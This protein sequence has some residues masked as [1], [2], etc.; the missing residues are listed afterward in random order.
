[1]TEPTQTTGNTSARLPLLLTKTYVPRA[2]PDL[3]ERPWLV[4]RLNEGLR[5]NL[6]L[7]S[8][9]AGY[10]KTTLLSKWIEVVQKPSAWLSLDERDNDPA[11]FWSYFVGA[12]Q[13]LFPG[14]GTTTLAMLQSTP[15]A[16]LENALSD[17]INEIALLTE[18]FLFVLDDFHAV[19]DDQII[20]GLAFLLE[21]FPPR[22]H[23]VVSSRTDPPFPLPLLRG[24]RQL[25]EIRLEDLR[26]YEA[27]VTLFINEIMGLDLSRT[28]IAALERLSEGWVAGLQ[29][30]AL[31][32]QGSEDV[33][34]IINSFGGSDRFVFDYL[35]QEVLARQDEQVRKFLISTSILERLSEDLCRSIL[36]EDPSEVG[37]TVVRGEPQ[38]TDEP[39][40]STDISRI[41]HFLEEANLFLVPLDHERRWY[42]YHHLFSGFLR[43]QLEREA[44]SG[45]I[46]GMHRRASR[47]YARQG[48]PS[49]AIFHALAA[50]DFTAVAGLIRASAIDL[51]KQ[52]E[53]ITLLGW[54]SELP[55]VVVAGDGHLSAIY[56]WALA[57]TSRFDEVEPQLKNIERLLGVEADG[58]QDS[59]LL[60]PETRGALGEVSLLRAVLAFNRYEIPRVLELTQQTREYLKEDVRSGLH[61]SRQ[62]LLG[63]AL[64]NLALAQEFS[65]DV[66]AATGAFQDSLPLI[67]DNLHLLPMVYSHLAQLLVVQG[68][69]HQ[70]WKTYDQAF[71][72]MEAFDRPSPFIGMLNS[73]LGNLLYEWND[74]D[75]ALFHLERGIQ[76]GKQWSHWEIL[77]AG[78]FGLTRV[79]IAR[80]D[81]QGAR[82][83]LDELTGLVSRLQVIWLLPA[84]DAYQAMLALHRGEVQAALG[85]AETF[86]AAGSALIPWIRETA[87]LILV[88]VFLAAGEWKKALLLSRQ[89]LDEAETG[90]RWGR[91]VEL[92]V[93][94]SVAL[95]ASGE[96]PPA[97]DAL[98]HALSLA[99]PE[100]YRRVFLDG[101]EP[102]RQLLESAVQS[103]P[104][105]DLAAYAQ[106]LLED[107]KKESLHPGEE[108]QPPF[109]GRRPAFRAGLPVEPLSERELQVLRL[110]A[111][112]SSNPEIAAQ[113]YISLNTVKS[114]LKN[115]YGKLGVTRRG[116]ATARARDLHLL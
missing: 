101:G 59:L 68:R 73:G 4:E 96:V 24:R 105:E 6:T 77:L 32:L 2:H 70:A 37:E 21:N 99:R 95:A 13:T 69:L 79:Q 49:E 56:A 113:L 55:E 19:K 93:L 63:A 39:L 31:S 107:F 64:F 15:P 111:A 94:Q 109:S 88:Q 14:M 65:G 3:V 1:M 52:S 36:A 27:E 43:A 11:R 40:P 82:A 108:P 42:R 83:S 100:G 72:A 84:V 20:A 30:A 33:S 57:A 25:L 23:L 51:F 26:F 48:Y 80:R 50:E 5:R 35:A 115:I 17:L 76:L 92:M 22:M 54:F 66:K 112:G 10:G 75:Q 106:S 87:N 104:G 90:Q 9:P 45:E 89:C 103:S 16:P 60:P 71:Q 78:F 67:Q 61:N 85:W 81:F 62:D 98:K 12:L 110:L 41:L 7:V 58:S 97:V 46:A 18:D 8:A 114:H 116:Q 74:L 34:K 28:D 47:W 38:S 29:L 91:V 86:Q 53:L 102:V 44:N